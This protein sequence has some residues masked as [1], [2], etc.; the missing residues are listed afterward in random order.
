M[1]KT[2]KHGI[3][4][5][6]NLV[7]D[8]FRNRDYANGVQVEDIITS[9]W[10]QYDMIWDSLSSIRLVTGSTASSVFSSNYKSDPSHSQRN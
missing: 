4:K 6:K 5:E 10:S 3:L 1:P 8:V 2:S 7:S 9:T